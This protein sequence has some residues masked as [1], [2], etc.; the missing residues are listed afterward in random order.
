MDCNSFYKNDGSFCEPPFF[1]FVWYD[2]VVKKGAF[3][4]KHF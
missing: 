1:V 4:P 3:A 2:G